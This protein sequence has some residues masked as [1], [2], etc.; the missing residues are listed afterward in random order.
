MTAAITN[1]IDVA[2]LVLY[3]FWFFF[4]GLIY[5][6]HREN[7]REGYPL[8]SSRGGTIKIQGFPPVPEPKVFTLPHNGGTVYAPR[9]EPP[10]QV[11]ATPAAPYPGS[12]MIPNG[13]PML[14]AFGPGASPDRMK[15]CD[16]TLEGQPKIVPLRVATDFSIAAEDPD[17]RGMTVLGLDGEVGGTITDVWVDRAEPQIRYL[18]MKVAKT[19]KQALLPINFTRFDKKNRQI[20]V[21]SIRGEHFANVPTLVNPDLV[22][23]Y[24]EDKVCAYYAGGHL[25][26]TADRAGPLL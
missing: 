10:C 5:Y 18:E 9:A 16:L 3:V 26:A 21:K 1:Y 12:P 24:E 7:K 25:Y 13:D 22:T 11:N 15:H 14:S 20:K 6:L 17:P 23:L 4:A 19:G 8:E 2:Q